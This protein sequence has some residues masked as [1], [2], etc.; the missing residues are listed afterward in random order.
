M[1][2]LLL[3]LLI[4]KPTDGFALRLY[5]NTFVFNRNITIDIRGVSKLF[6]TQQ[7]IL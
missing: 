4:L 1:T 3:V 5:V 7:R 2:I 6:K